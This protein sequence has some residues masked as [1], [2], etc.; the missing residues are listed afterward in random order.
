MNEFGRLVHGVWGQIKGTN[1][2]KFIQQEDIPQDRWGDKTYAWLVCNV[3][4]EKDEE[5][6]IQNTVG[7]NKVNYDEVC[8]MP[9]ADAMLV[10]IL[11]NSTISTEGAWFMTCNNKNFYLNTLLDCPEYVRIK[12]DNISHEIINEYELQSIVC[13]NGYVYL[14]VNK[15]LNRLKQQDLLAQQLLEKQLQEDRYS[16]SKL[17]PGL[18]THKTRPIIFTLVVDDFVVKYVGKEHREHL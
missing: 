16:Q 3:R 17:I 15:G 5:F 10:K 7:G 1:T 18:W 8:G 11:F 6:R 2:I 12:I 14:Q 4:P 9:T 13:K